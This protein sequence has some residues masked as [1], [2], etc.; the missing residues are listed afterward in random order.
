M[1]LIDIEKYE[2]LGQIA[3]KYGISGEDMNELK[4]IF[5]DIEEQEEIET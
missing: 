1:N 3:N 5:K 2:E 4:K